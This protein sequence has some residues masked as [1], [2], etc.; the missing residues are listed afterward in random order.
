[1]ERPPLIVSGSTYPK[2]AIDVSNLLGGD[3]CSGV[4]EPY[5][6][7]E[8]HPRLSKSVRKRDV[9]IIQSTCPPDINKS[10]MELFFMISACRISSANEITVVS[11]YT[12]YAR[13]DRLNEQRTTV[14]IGDLL[15]I[16]RERGAHRF[17][18]IDLHQE[19]SLVAFSGAQDHLYSSKIL[20]PQ[21]IKEITTYKQ[22]KNVIAAT[23][24]GGA[25][26]VEAYARLLRN[27]GINI[28]GTAYAIQNR[29][30]ITNK[31]V[32][33]GITGNVKGAH[34]RIVDD[35]LASGETAINAGNAFIND[36]AESV[37]LVIP[38]GLF[39]DSDGIGLIPISALA[40]LRNSS[41]KRVMITDTVCLGED[42]LAATNYVTVVKSAPLIAAAIACVHNGESLS[43]DLSKYLDEYTEKA[44]E[45]RNK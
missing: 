6:D 29:D 24:Q 9:Y 7:G 34:V 13:G 3:F 5:K 27:A 8:I 18:T 1:M 40:R 12:A 2:L 31:K 16:I 22:E 23:D 30:P 11:P 39:L 14:S 36:G 32:L 15:H 10:C 4:L 33:T 21:M 25:K 26:M 38:H 43:D 37:G 19:A 17:M 20:I 42:V 41:I 45:S 44:Q 35:V 28:S